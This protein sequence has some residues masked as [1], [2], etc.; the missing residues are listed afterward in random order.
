MPAPGWEAPC[1]GAFLLEA[2]AP[3]IDVRCAS[4]PRQSVLRS[5]SWTQDYVRGYLEAPRPTPHPPIST[6]VDSTRLVQDAV[7]ALTGIPS[8]TFDVVSS[9]ACPVVTVRRRSRTAGCTAGSVSAALAV[10]ARYGTLFVRAEVAAARLAC[11][12]DSENDQ[13][14]A[15]LGR[16]LAAYLSHYR[17]QV[18]S[19]IPAP[20]RR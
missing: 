13:T 7:N 1:S 12:D 5:H 15:S 3:V 8:A 9:A 19:L 4:R 2:S 11:P 18:L 16:A 10:I 17:A 14:R 20:Q 6:C